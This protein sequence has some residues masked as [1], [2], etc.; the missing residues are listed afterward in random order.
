MCLILKFCIWLNCGGSCSVGKDGDSVCVR[1]I[2]CRW[3]LVRLV[4]R[5][6]SS[7]VEVWGDVM[8][9]FFSDVNRLKLGSY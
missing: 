3:L 7:V 9:G 8:E 1:L 2:M 6:G 4:V 5:V